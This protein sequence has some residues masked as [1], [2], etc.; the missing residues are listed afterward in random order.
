MR[1][2]RLVGLVI[3]GLVGVLAQ[4]NAGTLKGTVYETD[5]TVLKNA[6]VS[7]SVKDSAGNLIGAGNAAADGSVLVSFD[8]SKLQADKLIQVEY[9]RN[10]VTVTIPTT[11]KLIGTTITHTLHVI[12]PGQ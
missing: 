8:S 11:A 1:N 7:I 5:G 12:V 9:K 2:V 10:A 6:T 4:A 3:L